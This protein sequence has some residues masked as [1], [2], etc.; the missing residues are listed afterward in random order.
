MHQTS[1]TL[2]ILGC[3]DYPRNAESCRWLFWQRVYLDFNCML[4]YAVA[5]G[6]KP[7]GNAFP[8]SSFSFLL[9]H[10]SWFVPW[11]SLRL[12]VLTILAE[13]LLLL[14]YRGS[15]QPRASFCSELTPGFPILYAVYWALHN[16]PWR[17]RLDEGQ[18]PRV[19]RLI[20]F[21]QGVFQRGVQWE[22]AHQ[23]SLLCHATTLW[24]TDAPQHS[25]AAFRHRLTK[26]TDWSSSA[27]PRLRCF[28]IPT[29][30]QHA[31]W[32]I[33]YSLRLET[34]TAL[35]WDPHMHPLNKT[36]RVLATAA[37]PTACFTLCHCSGKQQLMYAFHVS[38]LLKQRATRV[39][40][41]YYTR[42][43]THG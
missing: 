22:M 31:D 40:C 23:P 17:S 11:S 24:T 2:P 33:R 38:S 29:L 35:T 5:C 26:Q 41:N 12:C 4:S 10:E 15:S 39:L 14:W 16:V 42:I 18:A 1:G 27:F 6:V 21:A 9:F 7:R 36:P 32:S 43:H 13:L 19:I 37:E 30:L 34:R 8:F 20:A 25:L 3:Q 28:G